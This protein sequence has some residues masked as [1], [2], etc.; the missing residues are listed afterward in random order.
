MNIRLTDYGLNFSP[1]GP[2]LVNALEAYIVLTDAEQY[3]WLDQDAFPPRAIISPG[4]RL[5][6]EMAYQ[7]RR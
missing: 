4:M 6:R 1:S 2:L 3:V 5:Q 7:R